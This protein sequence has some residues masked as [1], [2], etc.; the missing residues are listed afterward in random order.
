MDETRKNN[1]IPQTKAAVKKTNYKSYFPFFI[2]ISAMAFIIAK[3]VP[4]PTV[5]M[6][7]VGGV[8]LLALGLGSFFNPELS[9]LILVAYV[10]FS[11]ILIGRFDAQITGLNLTNVLIFIVTLGWLANCYNTR[12]KIFTK[13]SLNLVVLLFC[14]WGFFSL[15]MARFLYGEFYDLESFFILFKRWVTPIFLYF[16]GLNMV[17]NRETFKK[18]MFVAMFSTFIIALMAIRDYMNVGGGSLEES[19]VG[20]VFEQPNMLG[21]FFVYNMFFFLSFFLYYYRSLKYWLLLIPFLACLRGIMVTFS[22]GAY[23][24]F[25]AGGIMTTFFRSKV[26]F[27]IAMFLFMASLINPIYLPQGM[28]ERLASTFG[29]EKVMSTNVEDI[30]DKSAGNR[31]IIWKGAIEMIKAKPMFGFG[32]GTFPYIIGYFIPAMKDVDAHNTYLIIAA[33]MGIPALLIFLLILFMLIKNAVWLL[34]RTKERYFK[35]FAVGILGNIFGLLLANM[36]GSRLNSEEVSSYFWIYAGLIMAA[37]NM[38]K[39]GEIN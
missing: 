34:K 6:L 30:T 7:P 3:D 33:E 23:L 8:G 31:I 27:I 25:G 19:R 39:K 32:Y 21:A 17:K 5:I 12:K 35:A 15:M 24:A 14:L 38:K 1:Q 10:P 26:L 22:R 13:S 37:V 28:R 18:V 36:F 9:L 2:F 20:G 11:K 4:I 16:I 29:G